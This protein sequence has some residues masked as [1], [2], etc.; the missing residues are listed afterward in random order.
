MRTILTAALLLLTATPAL[1]EAD[2]VHVGTG[3][4]E[5]QKDYIDRSSIRV[6]GQIRRY[7]V[8]RDL[9]NNPDGWKQT[10]A[11][12]ENNC[13]SGQW[14][15]IHLTVYYVDGKVSTSKAPDQSWDYVVPGSVGRIEHDYVC[16][17]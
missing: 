9:V 15:Q 1:A 14:R 6:T 12:I 2:W 4:D 10:V 8:R 7:W 17:K 13:A 5:T 16:R 3:T 11:L